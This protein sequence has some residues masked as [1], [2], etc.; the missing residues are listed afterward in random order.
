MVS[1]FM[2][3][4]TIVFAD[5]GLEN[6]TQYTEPFDGGDF[7]VTFTGGQN[8]GKYYNTGQAIRVYGNGTMTVAAKS[9][10]LKKIVLT[11]VD[12]A[13]YR[14]TSADVV[15]TGTYDVESCVWTGDTPT[16]IF[17]RPTG[18]G[19]WRVQAVE[20]T[21]EGGTVVE[22][23]T[24]EMSFSPSSLTITKGESFTEPTLS[25]NGD[26]SI[27]YSIDNDKVATIDARTGKLNIKGIGEAVI[28][29]SSTQTENYEQEKATYTLNV[30]SGEKQVYGVI[31]YL[32]PANVDPY[33][34]SCGVRQLNCVSCFVAE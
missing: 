24:P 11:F 4:G 6:S 23:K 7:T 25:Y 9:G 13:N 3:A 18:T 8:D 2:Y 29:A 34:G 16:V 10:N 28:T 1:A 20:A 21:V 22:K 32:G 15:D 30:K 33:S 27:T 26:G 19:H 12:D 5:L 31:T 14:P 17:T